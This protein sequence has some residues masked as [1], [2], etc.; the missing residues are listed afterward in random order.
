MKFKSFLLILIGLLSFSFSGEI[1]VKNNLKHEIS[2][3]FTEKE[4]NKYIHSTIKNLN[5]S[6][7]FFIKTK[8]GS[9]LSS[10]PTSS[11]R[12]F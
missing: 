1:S 10:R 8:V 2:Q 6:S 9:F 3:T 12:N 7:K 4:L 11:K 5:D